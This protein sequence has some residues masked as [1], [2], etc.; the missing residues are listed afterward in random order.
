MAQLCVITKNCQ[1]RHFFGKILLIKNKTIYTDS[2]KKHNSIFYIL[3]VNK[4]AS[5]WSDFPHF[6]GGESAVCFA[7]YRYTSVLGL[8]YMYIFV[9]NSAE[10]IL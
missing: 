9:K 8:Y 10:Q 3:S 1:D 7:I 6:P 2:V 4:S 5:G